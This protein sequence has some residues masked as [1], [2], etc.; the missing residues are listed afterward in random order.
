MVE[1]PSFFIHFHVNDNSLVNNIFYCVFVI[2]LPR[3]FNLMIKIRAI[4][5]FPLFISITNFVIVVNSL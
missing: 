3:F 5:E 1:W 2:K 4:P